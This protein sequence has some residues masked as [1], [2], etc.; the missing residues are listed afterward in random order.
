MISTVELQQKVIDRGLCVNC[1]ACQ[2]MCPYWRSI[3]GRNLHCFDCDR[4]DGRC[5]RFCPRMPTDTD[6]LRDRFFDPGFSLPGIGP[7]RGLYL[8]RASDR[9][10]RGGGQHG[11]TV[12]ALCALALREGM[13]DAAVLTRSR[14]GLDPQ[15]VLA[16]TE[17]QVRACGGSSF[18]IPATLE[19]LNRALSEGQ[20]RHIGV[21]GTPCKTLAVYKMKA[22]PFPEH[23][24]HA[25]RISLVIGLF[26]GWGLD[27]EGMQALVAR[28]ADPAGVSHIDIPPSKYH[29]MQVDD[30][31][32]EL[33][34][35]YP[36]VRESCRYCG[37]MTAEFSDLSVGGARS[38][39]GWEVDRGWNQVIARTERG[40]QLIKLALKQGVLEQKPVP[41]GNLERLVRAAEGKRSKALPF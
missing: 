31:R 16:V 34:E 15:G 6:A 29:C 30:V 41:E 40:E 28:H 17:E 2:G 8:T 19:V 14:G 7:F 21:V 11:G 22:Q 18:Q 36:I 3:D 9:D 23:D 32:V 26:C 35:V 4:E 25:D 37:D 1:G 5:V 20:Y 13:I 24:N 10:V 12:T 27:W 39:D 38:A 33:D